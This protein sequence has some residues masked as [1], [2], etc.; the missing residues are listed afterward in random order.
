MLNNLFHIISALFDHVMKTTSADHFMVLIQCHFTKRKW[1]QHTMKNIP[2]SHASIHL[3]TLNLHRTYTNVLSPCT[4]DTLP[5]VIQFESEHSWDSNEVFIGIWS[6]IYGLNWH[7]ILQI[8]RYSI[9]WWDSCLR[10][11]SDSNYCTW[12]QYEVIES[13]VRTKLYQS[14]LSKWSGHP[15]TVSCQWYP[16]K[17]W[18]PIVYIVKI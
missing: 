13:G 8:W 11:L 9:G 7:T 16:I 10:Y 12:P 4:G 18:W 17:S 2:S 1:M 5:Q 15:P 3:Q 14:K 6:C